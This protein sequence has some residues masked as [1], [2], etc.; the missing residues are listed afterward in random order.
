MLSSRTSFLVLVGLG[1]C[2]TTAVLA[3]EMA[4]AP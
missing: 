1:A 3:R 4:L 2:A